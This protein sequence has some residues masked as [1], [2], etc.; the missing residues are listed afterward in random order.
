MPKIRASFCIFDVPL[1][2]LDHVFPPRVGIGSGRLG[3]TE[4]PPKTAAKKPLWINGAFCAV[5]LCSKHLF[6]AWLSV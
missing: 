3:Y 1:C 5:G 6:L 4:I 2:L